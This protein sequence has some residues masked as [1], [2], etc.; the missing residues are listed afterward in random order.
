MSTTDACGVE[1]DVDL[2]DGE[3]RAVSCGAPTTL[4]SRTGDAYL[5]ADHAEEAALAG[6]TLES[7][8]PTEMAS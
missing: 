4:Y 7:M 6:A 5:C 1:V 8:E 2:V 3:W